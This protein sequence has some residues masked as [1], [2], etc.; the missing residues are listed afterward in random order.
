MS[1]QRR[2]DRTGVSARRLAGPRCTGRR[3]FAPSVRDAARGSDTSPIT[4]ASGTRKIVLARYA[5]NRRLADASQQW[6][7][8]SIPNTKRSAT[9]A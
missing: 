8:G 3:A 4:K 7:L 9:A 5:R 1:R 2:V 6:A